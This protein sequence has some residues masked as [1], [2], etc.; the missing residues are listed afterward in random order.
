M[1]Q[2]PIELAAFIDKFITFYTQH[3]QA[4]KDLQYKVVAIE[5]DYKDL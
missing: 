4:Q 2:D 3:R 1:N 5:K